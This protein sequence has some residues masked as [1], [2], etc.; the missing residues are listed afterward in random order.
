MKF[1]DNTQNVLKNLS[2]LNMGLILRQDA[3]T[4]S[5]KT[6][7]EVLAEWKPVE[8]FPFDFAIADLNAFLSTVS[9]FK[10]SEIEFE[11]DYIEISQGNSTVKYGYS[12]EIV[13]DAPADEDIQATKDITDDLEVSFVLTN[14]TL[15]SLH[16][17]SSVMK[18]DTVTFTASAGE[19]IV[20]VSDSEKVTTNKF[21]VNLGAINSEFTFV[22]PTERLKSVINASYEVC[23]DTRL[24]KLYS[25]PLSLTYWLSL[26]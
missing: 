26:D 9:M 19:L 3:P 15:V 17:A 12:N 23:V 13:V 14:E 16:K 7:R 22:M 21:T 4:Y 6:T 25:E 8:D 1:S 20:V 10:E 24:I 5:K 11:N 18:L 2:N